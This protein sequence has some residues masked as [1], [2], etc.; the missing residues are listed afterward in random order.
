MFPQIL[1]FKRI[2]QN[3]VQSCA[4]QEGKL[5]GGLDHGRIAA[6][7]DP[8]IRQSLVVGE[9]RRFGPAFARAG[10]L[11]CLGLL[12]GKAGNI[13]KSV[14][15]PGQIVHFI[16]VIQAVGRAATVIEVDFTCMARRQSIT[17]DA[18]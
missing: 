11:P 14:V 13:V 4:R 16:H 3:I 2:R 6:Q 1:Q 18:I 15:F 5:F 7:I 17:G 12:T 10:R 9:S 8:P